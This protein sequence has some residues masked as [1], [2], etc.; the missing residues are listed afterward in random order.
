MY[1]R[2]SDENY[3]R[4]LSHCGRT[5]TAAVGVGVEMVLLEGNLPHAESLP[6]GKIVIFSGFPDC[7]QHE[8]ELAFVLAHELG[9][10]VGR[11]AEQ[12][13]ALA[14]TE[15]GAQEAEA[16]R[17]RCELEADR[18]GLL[19]MA[20]AG[21]DPRVGLRFWRRFISTPQAVL[22]QQLAGTHP[23]HEERIRALELQLPEAVKL[24]NAAPEKRGAG[25]R[26]QHDSVTGA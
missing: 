12:A 2:C 16:H 6:G 14:A 19:L 15:A 5:L 8:A 4:I 7:M 3:N 25:L 26:I 21:Y 1:S 18:M 13:M 11:H 24:Y 9:H 20:R 22:Q 23:N 17:L 10:V